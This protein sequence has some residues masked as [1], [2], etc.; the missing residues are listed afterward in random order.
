M[1]AIDRLPTLADRPRMA[2]PKPS[3]RVLAKPLEKKSKEAKHKAFRRAVWIR[4]HGKSRASGKPLAH[5]GVDYS[6]VG[7]VH[8]VLARSTHPDKVFE[9]AI[10]ILLSKSEHQLAETRCPHAAHMLLEIVGPPDM[11]LP[12]RFVWRDVMGKILKERIG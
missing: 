10:G 11:G 9:V 5:S 1:S 12:Q 8:H 3:P 4:D 7:E 2:C 6:A